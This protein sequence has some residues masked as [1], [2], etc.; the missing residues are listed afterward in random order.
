MG[1]A[2]P[3]SRFDIDAFLA[4]ES[5]Q[6]TRHEYLQGEVFAMTG[7]RDAHN[8]IALNI[9]AHLR[10]ALRGGPC[11]V[12][13]ADM[14]LRLDATDA[15]FYPDVMVTCDARDR[16]PEADQFKRH[17]ILI[18]EVLSESTAAYDRG[19]KFEYYRG[20][21]SLQEVLLVEQDR[22]HVDLYRRAERGHWL[23]ESH[24]PGGQLHLASLGVSLPLGVIY[25]DV[26]FP[27]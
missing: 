2:Q 23:L 21:D 27:R 19:R 4:W 18:V 10:T 6:P 11:R 22:P 12:Y 5:E 9:A 7:A 20:I 1:F 13:I 17:P 14:K 25:E 24:G 3:V 15:V 16:S 8:T 26:A